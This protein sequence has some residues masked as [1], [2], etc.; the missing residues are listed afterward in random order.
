MDDLPW[1]I[2][3][4]ES[5]RRSGRELGAQVLQRIV[6]L[7]LGDRNGHAAIAVDDLVASEAVSAG[8]C[9][10]DQHRKIGADCPGRIR[11]DLEALQLRMIAV[12]ADADSRAACVLHSAIRAGQESADRLSRLHGGLVV[13][14]VP[15]ALDHHQRRVRKA[16]LEVVLGSDGRDVVLGGCD[17]QRR[18]GNRRSR[19]GDIV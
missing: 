3:N 11:A 9:L 17:Q 6:D 7:T 19:L 2:E 10:G 13:D 18:L 15:H 12:V 1:R 5:L 4:R 14:Q 16:L 8:T